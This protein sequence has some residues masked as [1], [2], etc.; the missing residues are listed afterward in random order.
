MTASLLIRQAVKNCLVDFFRLGGKVV[1]HFA[2]KTLAEM[3]GNLPP[4]NRKSQKILRK[5]GSKRA[6]ISVF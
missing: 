2:K 6:K 4:F 1:N 3:G 5:N